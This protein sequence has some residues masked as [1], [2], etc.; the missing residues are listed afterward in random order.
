MA[1]MSCRRDIFSVEQW[2]VWTRIH[3]RNMMPRTVFYKPMILLIPVE[4]RDQKRYIDFSPEKAIVC[5]DRF[6]ILGRERTLMM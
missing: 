4:D 1:S 5:F 2:N 3:I 6:E